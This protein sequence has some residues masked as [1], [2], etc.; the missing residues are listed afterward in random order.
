MSK[1]SSA[2][3]RCI[4][5]EPAPSDHV[6]DEAPTTVVCEPLVV[7]GAARTRGTMSMRRKAGTTPE[8]ARAI[9]ST[10]QARVKGLRHLEAS[11]DDVA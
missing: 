2:I 6:P 11:G 8:E 7:P 9:A 1:P 4:V 3:D 10:Q 5:R